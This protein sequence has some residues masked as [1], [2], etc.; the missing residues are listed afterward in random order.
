VT[1]PVLS[2]RD[3]VTEFD[4]RQGR[5]RAVRGISFDLYP[6]ETLGIVGESGSGKSVTVQSIMGLTPGNIIEGEVLY[7]GRDL[8]KLRASEFRRLRGR[9]LAMIFQDP[10]TSLNPVLSVGAQIA[11]AINQHSPGLPK[12]EVRRR[13]VE[14]LRV[15]GVPD[16]D[17]RVDQYPHQ[18]SGGMRQRAMIAMAIVNEPTVL[19]ADEPTTALD[20]TIQAQVLRALKDAQEKTGA[21]TIMITHDLGV[22]AETADR[23]LVM[24]AGRVVE[25]GTVAQIFNEP[26]HP[27]TRGLLRSLP[28]LDV[29][30]ERLSQV[31]GQPPNVLRLPPGCALNPRCDVMKGRDLCVRQRPKLTEVGPNHFSACHFAGELEGLPLYPDIVVG[32]TSAA[33]TTPKVDKSAGLGPEILRVEGLK[34]HFP[35][36]GGVT[37]R[38]VG[39]VF[40][41]DGIDLTLRAGETLGLVGESGCG[42]STTGRAIL[43]LVEPTAGRILFEDQDI[44]ELSRWKMRSVRR[45]LQLIFQDPYASLDPRMTVRDLIAEPMR[46]HGEWRNNGDTRVKEL[47]DIVGLSPDHAD[48]FPHQFSGGQRQRIG[49]ARA[50][51]LNPRVLVLD[52]PVSALDVSIQAQVINLLQELQR[53]LGLSFILI[54]HDLAV[55]RHISHR[56]AVMYLGKIVEVGTA[57]EL[58]ANPTHPYTQSLLSAVPVPEVGGE[59]QRE[60][61]LLTGDVPNPAK[62][63]SGCNFRTRCFKA[64]DHCAEVEPEL[65]LGEHLGHPSACHYAEPRSMAYTSRA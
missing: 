25:S 58:Y 16:P 38:Q 56:V 55:V 13:C 28:R 42:K 7:K 46:I 34:V 36:R 40:A 22:I 44:T 61:I 9:D 45:H 51:A 3:L 57:S 43:R 27:Y 60:R 59:I 37:R 63:P 65:S 26:Q 31:D 15:V 12:A 11:E 32:A 1:E 8:R 10:M 41:V 48:R 50:L 53:E 20:V 21:A 39:S 64:T 52:E 24:Y 35:I 6:G 2:V 30:L 19:I 47:L 49:I 18:Y 23:V 62:P 33:P 54:A 5:F 14:V 29:E 17:A 4:T